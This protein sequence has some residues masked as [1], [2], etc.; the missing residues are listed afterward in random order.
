[1]GNDNDKLNKISL[2]NKDF[3]QIEKISR[4]LTF[5]EDLDIKRNLFLNSVRNPQRTLPIDKSICIS[6]YPKYLH[7]FIKDC[8]LEYPKNLK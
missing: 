4:S 6:S 1:M 5:K 3:S 2:H 7:E 8:L